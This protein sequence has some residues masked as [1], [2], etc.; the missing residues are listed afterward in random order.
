MKILLKDVASRCRHIIFYHIS[1]CMLY[2][3]RIYMCSLFCSFSVRSTHNGW[4]STALWHTDT[5]TA[6]AAEVYRNTMAGRV[7]LQHLAVFVS[8]SY[9]CT[10]NL[11]NARVYVRPIREAF[12]ANGI[13]FLYRD[14]GRSTEKKYHKNA[15]DRKKNT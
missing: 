7:D 11:S 4:R 10:Y 13:R 5:H 12:D 3:I 9:L 2:Y 8:L 6:G 15:C 14:D 1:V